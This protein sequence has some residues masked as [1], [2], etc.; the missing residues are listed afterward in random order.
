[1]DLL[2][3]G[4]RADHILVLAVVVGVPDGHCHV[5]LPNVQRW[6]WR[7]R[8]QLALVALVGDDVLN[9]HGVAR[10]PHQPS[11]DVIRQ[12]LVHLARRRGREHVPPIRARRKWHVLSAQQVADAIHQDAVR[13]G[14]F[15]VHRIPV[16]RGADDI[17]IVAIIVGVQ[18]MH[19]E[20]G[21]ASQWA[22]SSDSVRA[23][24]ATN[25]FK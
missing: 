23:A 2:A 18:D 4:R 13:Q 6:R 12:P 9:E 25:A 21:L 5:A 15:A 11:R 19:R 17:L 24:T 22:V 1:M 7:R 3:V 14:A 16:C 8:R 20:V 10:V